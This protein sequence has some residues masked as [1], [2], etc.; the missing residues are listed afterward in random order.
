MLRW[1]IGACLALLFG[2]GCGARTPLGI[3]PP[4]SCTAQPADCGPVAAGAEGVVLFGG[5]GCTGGLGS[6]PLFCVESDTWT[7]NGASWTQQNVAGPGTWFVDGAATLD[8]AAVLLGD[9]PRE[10][11]GGFFD[12]VPS[13]WTWNGA[14]WTEQDVGPSATWSAGMTQFDG[15]VVLFGGD[16][17]GGG[18]L[19]TWN[20]TTWTSATG[21]TPP[22]QRK[23][24]VLS[25]SN[26]SLVL[27]GGRDPSTGD[28]GDTWTWDGAQ[29]TERSVLGPP[30]RDSAAMA[31]LNGEIVLFGGQSLL[32]G[33]TTPSSGAGE[34]LADTWTWDGASWTQRDVVGPSARWGAAIAAL[35]GALVL[36][37]GVDASGNT[38]G[39]TWTWDGTRWSARDV[40]GPSPRYAAAAA[41]VGP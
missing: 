26:G 39:D 14:T 6:D 5:Y 19:W 15:T 29:W 21:L 32:G 10:P 31:T 11:D 9:L 28:L 3:D 18:V 2:T 1:I 12:F 30:A 34:T 13:T 22:G 35:D 41:T 8:G 36:F 38:L 40:A 7:W 17:A 25:A 27:F 16:A 20:G 37:G 4:A 24:G 33:S 23:G